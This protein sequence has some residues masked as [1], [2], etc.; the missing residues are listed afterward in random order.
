MSKV[1]MIVTNDEYETPVKLDVIGVKK[2]AEFIGVSENK[3]RLMLCGANKWK[4]EYKAVLVDDANLTKKN[5]YMRYK[6]Y[7]MKHDRTEYDRQRYKKRKENA[8]SQ[9]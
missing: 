9:G 1:Y 5:Q 2:V 3:A 4:T 7:S 8:C 6:R